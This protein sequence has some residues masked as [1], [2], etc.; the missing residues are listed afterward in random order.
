[1]T[2]KKTL[3]VTGK[4]A[5]PSLRQSLAGLGEAFIQPWEIEVL[6]INVVA[7]ATTDWIRSH[8]KVPEGITEILLPGL[9]RGSEV[10][11]SKDLGIQVNKGPKDLRDLP[12]HFNMTK[13][14]MGPDSKK[15]N[16]EI[17][18]E[19]NN[20]PSLSYNQILNASQAFINQGA[21]TI[22]LGCTPGQIW[23][24]LGRTVQALKRAGL[25][26]S[27]DTF[28]P[29][30]A[31]WAAESGA[32]LLLSVHDEN[33]AE[34]VGLDL[35]FVVVPN[36]P[37]DFDSLK[38][39]VDILLAKNKKFRID[40]ILEP[41]PFG[42]TKSIVHYF[43]AREVF[44]DIP[45]LMGIGNITELV[46]G[47]SSGINTLLI[48]I[49]QECGIQSV[50][51]TSVINWCQTSVEEIHLARSL[52]YYAVTNQTL[53]KRLENRLL[54][55]RDPFLRKYGTSTL[56]RLASELKDRNLRIF[57]EDNKIH[58]INK[59]L[60]LTSEDPFELFEEIRKWENIDPQHA[61]YLGF[62]FCKAMMANQLGKNYTQDQELQWGFLTKEERI[63][64]NSS[65][66]KATKLKQNDD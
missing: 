7:L 28:N 48:G 3:F 53:P 1:M 37:G 14:N 30:E 55:L 26:V 57:A 65:P 34:L 50:L 41:I 24:D 11:L 43:K 20:A 52:M 66:P 47:D 60:Y 31:I 4:L 16:I 44:P 5:E 62:E 13:K 23:T 6:P 40:P 64:R 54:L 42:F 61:F 25:N 15:H 59:N 8:I 17:I 29:K 33:L 46:D 27:V 45:I 36:K 58:A 22:D 49:C 56:R 51:T 12:M 63:H 2:E 32:D 39:S 19:I 10:Q 9:C 18:A 21:D 38:R 35:E